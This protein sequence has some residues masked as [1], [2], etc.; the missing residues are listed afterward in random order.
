M[1]WYL[2]HTKPRQENIALEN[3]QQQGYT[4]YL[5]LFNVEKI[6]RG[7]LAVVLEALFPR[8]LF[9]QLDTALSSQSWTPIRSTKGV[10]RLVAFGGQPAKV[11]EA[12]VSILKVA[13]ETQPDRLQ[14]MF[15]FGDKVQLI[16]GAFAGL[17]GIY[18][19]ADGESRAM[20]LIEILSKPVRIAVEPA[21]LRK[22][23]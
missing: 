8:Y 20:V 7:K 3:L 13:E 10:N 2:I 12:L 19:M 11:D 14:K 15:T 23:E 4:C 9:I 21:E 6:R 18:Q 16:Q 22:L 1:H 17:E 5:P